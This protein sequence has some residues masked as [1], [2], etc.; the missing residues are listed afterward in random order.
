MMTKMIKAD[1]MKLLVLILTV[2]TVLP[3][4]SVLS[5]CNPPKFEG[6]Y[7]LY[8]TPFFEIN[9]NKI[10]HQLDKKNWMHGN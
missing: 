3:F 8:D 4:L 7:K 9:K 6:F 1:V 10:L 2:L 5:T